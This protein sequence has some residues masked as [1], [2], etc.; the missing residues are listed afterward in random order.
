MRAHHARWSCRHHRRAYQT[1]H[2]TLRPN[3]QVPLWCQRAADADAHN[4]GLVVWDYH[5]FVLEAVLSQACEPLQITGGVPSCLAPVGDV[6]GRDRAPT[7]AAT[8]NGGS[9]SSCRA[10]P[11]DSEPAACG[12]GVAAVRVWDLDTT[13]GFPVSGEAYAQLALRLLPPPAP[14]EPSGRVPR[15]CAPRPSW[16][17]FYRVVPA[18]DYLSHFSSDRSHM[19]LQAGLALGDGEA[20][21]NV[22][23]DDGGGG[24]M[25]SGTEGQG[26]QQQQ[27]CHGRRQQGAAGWTA[28]PP[29]WPP[30]AGPCSS[31]AHELPRYWDVGPHNVAGSLLWSP[32]ATATAATATATSTGRLALGRSGSGS[33]GRGGDEGAQSAGTGHGCRGDSLMG[34]AAGGGVDGD[35]FGAMGWVL[36]DLSFARLLMCCSD[37]AAHSEAGHD[38]AAR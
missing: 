33:C 20:R 17:R 9:S 31:S 38:R 16:G 19:R 7:A 27:Q 23:G 1:R 2:P 13:L 4:G 37:G 10:A 26:Q 36:D 11:E 8:R 18:P 5:V 22:H 34:M 25:Q 3:R 14:S 30:I 24:P 28:D 32:M 15:P 6:E 12:M 29:P 21:L 35:G